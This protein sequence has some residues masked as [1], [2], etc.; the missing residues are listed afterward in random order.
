MSNTGAAV[1]Q[2]GEERR[3][4]TWRVPGGVACG[5]SG[6]ARRV[7]EGRW[8]GDCQDLCPGLAED[9]GIRCW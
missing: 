5:G 2:Q 3:G 1:N 4:E 9:A 8:S 7:P 6:G